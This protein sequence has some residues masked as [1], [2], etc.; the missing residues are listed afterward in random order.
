MVTCALE[1]AISHVR[2]VSRQETR[3]NIDFPTRELL[4]DEA[5]VCD[6][7]ALSVSDRPKQVR[8]AC[9]PSVFMK[10][11]F[12]FPPAESHL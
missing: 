2:K 8:K 6:R 1:E 11:A 5:I 12:D 10:S 7:I 4:D 3:Q 9:S